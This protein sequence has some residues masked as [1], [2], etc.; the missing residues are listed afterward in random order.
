M[1]SCVIEDFGRNARPFWYEWGRVG[2]A[3]G[4][5]SCG[6]GL[7]GFRCMTPPLPPFFY[8][9]GIRCLGAHFCVVSDP[10]GGFFTVLLGDGGVFTWG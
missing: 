10:S 4:F 7:F 2:V 6:G 8:W 3:W 1:W 5:L 9:V